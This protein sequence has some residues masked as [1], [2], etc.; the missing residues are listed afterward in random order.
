MDML[1]DLSAAPLRR[2][3]SDPLTRRAGNIGCPSASSGRT[4]SWPCTESEDGGPSRTGRPARS[5]RGH[6]AFYRRNLCSTN[7]ILQTIHMIDQQHL[8]VRTITMG[9]SLLACA[10]RPRAGL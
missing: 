9:I 1:V 4:S 3:M 6:T 2:Q 7:E 5:P 10:P 8:D